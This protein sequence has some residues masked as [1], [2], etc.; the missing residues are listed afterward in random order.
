MAAARG[1]ALI[2]CAALAACAVLAATGCVSVRSHEPAPQQYLLT[3]ASPAPVSVTDSAGAP[4]ASLQV[5]Q[6]GA[7]PGLAGE[8]I[9][10]ERSG[11]RLDYFSGVRWAATAPAMIETLAVQALRRA[12]HFRLVESNTGPFTAGLVLAIEL[13]HFEADYTAGAGQTRDD[14]APMVRVA[15]VATLGRHNGQVLRQFTVTRS[16]RADANRMQAVIAAFR[17]ATDAVLTQLAGQLGPEPLPQS[18][19]Q[20]RG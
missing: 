13:T 4:S 6:P 3:L 2:L 18:A 7:A 20:S 5:L 15:L 1:V 17:E 10:V 9:A 8:G 12:G 19:A 14:D 11:Q 16:V